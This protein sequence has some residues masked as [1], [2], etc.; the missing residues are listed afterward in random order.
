MSYHIFK[1]WFFSLLLSLL[2]SLLLL[3]VS[4]V[5]LDIRPTLTFF[6]K[7]V[8]TIII[9]TFLA[10]PKSLSFITIIIAYQCYHITTVIA[11]TGINTTTINITTVLFTTT[12]TTDN[13]VT[14]KTDITT[15]SDIITTANTTTNHSLGE[16]SRKEE[17]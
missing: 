12:I 9:A 14:I 10:F 8:T 13:T 1:F 3:H 5:H 6:N 2:R 11:T 15:T 17:L 7:V 16:I 4:N